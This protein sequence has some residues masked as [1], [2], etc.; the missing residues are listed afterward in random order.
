MDHL[1]PF[2]PPKTVK[3]GV[4]VAGDTLSRKDLGQVREFIAGQPETVRFIAQEVRNE[5]SQ[6]RYLY[7]RFAGS[8]FSNFKRKAS[9][10]VPDYAAG[11]V[12]ELVQPIA[13]CETLVSSRYHGLLIG[14]W[15]GCKIAAIGR[16]SKVSAL[17][18]QLQIPCCTP[19]LTIS[20]LEELRSRAVAVDPASLRRLSETAR[21]GIAFALTSEAPRTAAALPAN[22]A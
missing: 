12:A 11:S 16:S 2:L 17:A 20:N 22:A 4:I 1:S 6:E 9:L 13:E 7:S 8:W 19:P 3:L 5:R 18:R 15:A 21:A 10:S 14:A